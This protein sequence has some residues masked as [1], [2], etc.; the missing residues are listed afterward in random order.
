MAKSNL[1]FCT[2]F[3][4]NMTFTDIAWSKVMIAYTSLWILLSSSPIS[5]K[6][7]T[8]QCISSTCSATVSNVHLPSNELM[9]PWTI[10]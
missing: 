5:S 6:S 10:M 4:I 1:L 7:K 8:Y 9:D 2:E 3:S